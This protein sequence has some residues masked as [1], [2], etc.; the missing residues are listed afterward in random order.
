MTGREIVQGAKG[1]SLAYECEYQQTGWD[2]YI[3]QHIEEFKDE[4]DA[5]EAVKAF[6]ANPF[7]HEVVKEKHLNNWIVSYLF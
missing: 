6:S 4:S 7:N 5:D 3:F 1:S 2:T